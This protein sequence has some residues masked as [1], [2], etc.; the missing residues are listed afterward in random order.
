MKQ[1]S[2]NYQVKMADQCRSRSHI[3]VTLISSGQSYFFNDDQ[4]S[5]AVKANEVDPLTRRVPKETFTFSIFDFAGEYNPS[6]P[7]GKWSSMDENAEIK[8]E[9][10]FDV[11][12]G[13]T[14]WLAPDFYYLDAK[15]TVSGGIATFK[16]SSKLCKLTNTYY[17]GVYANSNLYDL[18]IAVLTDAGISSNNYYVDSSL[19]SMATNAPIPVSS[20]INCLQLIAHAARCT[21]R[22]VSG[23]IKV[24]PFDLSITPSEFIIGL[25]SI[26]AN[27][28]TISKIETLYKVEANLYVYT[29]DA[30][31]SV[32][33]TFIIDAT[34]ETPCHIEYP[35]STDQTITV[36]GAA[37]IS[38]INVYAS[39]ADFTLDGTG[40][41]SVTVTGKKIS[42]SVSTTESI[43]SLNTNGS[44]DSE[45]NQLITTAALQFSLIYHVANYLQFRLTHTVKYRGNPELE[46]LDAIYFATIYGTY[47]SALVLSHTITFNG[48]I[49]GS[50][51]LKSISEI[52]DT[53][54]YDSTP[55]I[56]LDSQDERVSVIGVSDYQSEYSTED[57]NDFI[58]EVISNGET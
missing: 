3:R 27:G 41:F 23:V 44:T 22:T 38:N 48:A 28:D 13:V 9:F 17:K 1:T 43:I 24:E 35:I 25:D 4:I 50:I 5:S 30:E 14:E 2:E 18:A 34:G 36:D 21:L 10:G 20:H 6:N 37:T 7:S 49:S 57:M 58:E 42:T 46:A 52:S 54:L 33:S 16:S 19:S 51:I 15:P 39:A 40:S 32:L 53:Y 31:S 45:K 56:V 11:S 26:Q 8:V 47:I 55:E 29:P 12:N